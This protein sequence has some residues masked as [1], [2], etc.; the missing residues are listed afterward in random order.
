M[1]IFVEHEISI[2]GICPVTGGRDCYSAKIRV[3]R[4]VKVEDIIAAM[5]NLPKQ[6]MYQ[7][8]LTAHIAIILEAEVETIGHHSGIRTKVIC[9][10]AR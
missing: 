3:R 7:E 9:G 4:I 6:P 2:S 8:D 5:D 10:E 1:N